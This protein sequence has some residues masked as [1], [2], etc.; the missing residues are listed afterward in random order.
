MSNSLIVRGCRA[1]RRLSVQFG[2][3]FIKD[4]LTACVD[5]F[6]YSLPIT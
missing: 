4:Y 5:L 1:N 3:G 6:Y 2:I